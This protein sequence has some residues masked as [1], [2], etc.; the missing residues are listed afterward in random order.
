MDRILENIRDEPFGFVYWRTLE[1]EVM[2]LCPDFLDAV[3]DYLYDEDDMVLISNIGRVLED[4]LEAP[5]VENDVRN[6]Y[7]L[8]D[9]E[10]KGF[11][12]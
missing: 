5:Q 3:R 12:V 8:L 7:R 1:K 6:I 11:I 10:Q 9:I 2:D 4:L